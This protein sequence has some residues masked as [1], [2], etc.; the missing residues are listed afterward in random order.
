MGCVQVKK[1]GKY[2][3]EKRT[4]PFD[5][6]VTKDGEGSIFFDAKTRQGDS[7]TYSDFW[8]SKSTKHQ[9]LTLASLA[10]FGE[11]AGFMVWFRASDRICFIPATKIATMKARTSFGPDDGLPLGTFDNF[12]IERLWNDFE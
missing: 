5:F 3:L 4:N 8:S 12:E 2:V 9:V 6:I 10:N 7:I 1:R 11:R